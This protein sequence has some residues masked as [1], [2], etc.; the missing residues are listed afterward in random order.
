MV[1]SPDRKVGVSVLTNTQGPECRQI[2]RTAPQSSRPSIKPQILRV[3]FD[4]MFLQQQHEFFLIGTATMMVF[5]I[6]NIAFGASQ[7]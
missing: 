7:T 1:V 5:L 3:I 2:D 4:L 6:P